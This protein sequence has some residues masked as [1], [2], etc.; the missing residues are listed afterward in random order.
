MNYVPGETIASQTNLTALQWAYA[1]VPC[2]LK[3]MAIVALARLQRQSL[4]QK[5]TS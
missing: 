3:C 1:G 5:E 2:A 4:F